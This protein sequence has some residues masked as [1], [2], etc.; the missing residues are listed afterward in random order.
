MTWNWVLYVFE[1]IKCVQNYI[2]ENCLVYLP[3][4][5]KSDEI[6]KRFSGSVRYLLKN[7]PYVCSFSTD[8]EPTSTGTMVN[9]PRRLNN[10]EQIKSCN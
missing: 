8:S 3:Q 2:C 9:C 10:L 5:Q 1:I 4:W 6:T 7:F